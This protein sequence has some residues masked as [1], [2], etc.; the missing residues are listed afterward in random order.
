MQNFK[1]IK[2]DQNKPE[3]EVVDGRN[4]CIRKKFNDGTGN[5]QGFAFADYDFRNDNQIS[6][7]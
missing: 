4:T 2:R 5:L 3:R 7:W 1:M 6:K